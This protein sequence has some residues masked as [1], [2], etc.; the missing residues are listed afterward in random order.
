M[1]RTYGRIGMEDGA[2]LGEQQVLVM[3][4]IFECFIH[5]EEGC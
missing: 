5:L 1:Y 3:V 2:C 4:I